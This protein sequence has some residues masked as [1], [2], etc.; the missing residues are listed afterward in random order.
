[1]PDG[2]RIVFIALGVLFFL[3]HVAW[4]AYAVRFARSREQRIEAYRFCRPGSCGSS[5]GIE[6]VV[7][8]VA[9]GDPSAGTYLPDAYFRACV[10]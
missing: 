9:L 4:I 3:A 5:P 10:V 1:M 2:L 7:G 8:A 6:R